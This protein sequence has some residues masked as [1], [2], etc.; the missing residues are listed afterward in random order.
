MPDAAPEDHG[1]MISSAP[2]LDTDSMASRPPSGVVRVSSTS[3]SKRMSLPAASSMAWISSKASSAALPLR[4]HE[5][6]DDD[7]HE[8]DDRA[9]LQWRTEP[10]AGEVDA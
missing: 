10:V 8:G 4:P 7:D 3:S 6:H 9:V 1:P 2:A 5:Q